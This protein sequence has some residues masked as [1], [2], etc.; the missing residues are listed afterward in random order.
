MSE[1]FARRDLVELV[2]EHVVADSDQDLDATIGFFA[3][4]AVWDTGDLGLGIFEGVTAIRGHFASWWAT[5]KDHHLEIEEI[6]DL[7]HGVVYAAV[8]EDCR[9]TGS[10]RSVEQLRGR[11]VLCTCGKIARVTIYLDIAEGRA[12]AERL[13]EERE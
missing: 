8:R 7:G 10:E 9:V 3:A 4:D 12:A 2:R 6:V 5:W 11:V 13:A 1:E